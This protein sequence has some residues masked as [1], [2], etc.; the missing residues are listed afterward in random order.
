MTGAR[1]YKDDLA[2]DF[3]LGLTDGAEKIRAE[4]WFE[5]DEVFATIVY[6][7]RE[8]MTEIDRTA[9]EQKHTSLTW[10]GLEKA[11]DPRSAIPAVQAQVRREGWFSGLWES[12]GFWRPAAMATGFATILLAV[13]LVGQMLQPAAQ[14]VYVA[15]LQTGEGRSAAVV[16]AYADGTVTLV[17]LESIGVPE[18][19]ILEVWTLQTREQGPVSIGRMDRARTLKLDLKSLNRPDAGHLFEIT[20]E[21]TGGSP[22]GKPTG[23]ILMKGLTSTAL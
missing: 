14:P 1:K 10:E 21:P 18:G 22:T 3:V 6:T 11:L 19:R 4:R 7:C 20:V 5:T 12:L 17:P 9:P 8:K 2:V 15:V 23:P 16:N 13:G